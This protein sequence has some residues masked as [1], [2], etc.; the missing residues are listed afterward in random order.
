MKKVLVVFPDVMRYNQYQEYIN[1]YNINV[2]YGDG[3]TNLYCYLDEDGITITI[4]NFQAKVTR[5]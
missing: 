3:K 5:L 4:A 2:I 1:G